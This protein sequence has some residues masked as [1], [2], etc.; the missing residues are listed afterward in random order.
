MHKFR[1]NMLFIFFMGRGRAPNGIG[2][3]M[4]SIARLK[5][6][7]FRYHVK[8]I[9][10]TVQGFGF[11]SAILDEAKLKAGYYY[12]GGSAAII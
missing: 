6:G 1:Y 7:L 3:L 12:G 2:Q 8:R 10:F 4:I 9:H 5:G 11:L